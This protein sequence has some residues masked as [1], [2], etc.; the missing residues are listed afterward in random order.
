MS[1]L[2]L[3]PRRRTQVTRTAQD[4]VIRV[5]GMG[6]RARTPLPGRLIGLLVR[7]RRTG[8]PR[9]GGAPIVPERRPSIW[10]ASAPLWV[11]AF[12]VAKPGMRTLTSGSARGRQPIRALPNPRAPLQR[13]RR[14]PGRREVA[15]R[16]EAV[17]SRR[18]RTCSQLLGGQRRRTSCVRSTR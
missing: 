2:T 10:W 15:V 11:S 13:L 18:I 4:G 1:K 9:R 6:P 5:R 17:T 14:S 12:G 7:R 16:A 8:T 3:R